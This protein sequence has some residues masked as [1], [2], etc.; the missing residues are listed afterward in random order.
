MML[1]VSTIE[2]AMERLEQAIRLNGTDYLDLVKTL[3]S[4]HADTV[5]Q[6]AACV[7]LL[8]PATEIELIDISAAAGRILAESVISEHDVPGFD[9]STVD[10]YAVRAA[11]TFGASESL[12]AML[13]LDGSIKMGRSAGIMLASGCCREIATG[14]AMPEGADAVIMIEDTEPADPEDELRYLLKPVSPGQNIIFRGDDI[15]AGSCLLAAGITLMPHHIGALAA[16]GKTSVS[17][18]RKLKIALISTGDELVKPGDNLT[19]GQIY[20]V[21]ASMLT[22]MLKRAGT[23]INSFGIV[24][25]ELADLTSAISSASEDHDLVI[26]SG[27][28]SAGDRDHAAAAIAKHGQPGVIQH[29]LAVKPGKPTLIGLSDRL[30]I[31]GL[32]GHPVAAWFMADQI[33]LPLINLLCGRKPL[34]RKSIDA[35]LARAIPANHGRQGFSA[36]MLQE[37]QRSQMPSAVP[38]ASKSGLITT[39]RATDGY[40]MIDRNQEG[41]NSGSKVQVYLWEEQ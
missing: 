21:N 38:I 2:D 37:D 32:P 1:N 24:S 31:I 10:G 13:R 19:D 35:I 14:G 30:P 15:T 7:D 26:I 11:D 41:L 39:L 16:L 6:A 9:R 18:L 28:S 20:D 36:V 5:G 12:P 17:V 23:E 29:G 34:I 33:V 27:G 3:R 8:I 4:F 40:I 22:A 25:D